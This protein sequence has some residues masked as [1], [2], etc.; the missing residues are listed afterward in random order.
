MASRTASRILLDAPSLE[1]SL[2]PSLA[3]RSSLSVLCFFE[4]FDA[5]FSSHL[6]QSCSS[7][8]VR[9]DF[10]VGESNS[11][12]FSAPPM[13]D[14]IV[15]IK[16]ASS[17]RPLPTL[18]TTSEG[19]TGHA[20]DPGAVRP[21]V[22]TTVFVSGNMKII[23]PSSPKLTATGACG[24]FLP[25]IGPLMASALIPHDVFVVRGAQHCVPVALTGT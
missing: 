2:E 21:R 5:F 16:Y 23:D 11:T 24:A 10:F 3:T 9:F 14:Q 22:T 1:P 13:A 25:S 19:A 18:A 6:C 17:L 12:G 15:R 8:A 7:A 4:C 20:G